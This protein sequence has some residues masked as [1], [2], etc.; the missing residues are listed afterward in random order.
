VAV[1]VAGAA[2]LLA[3]LDA[4]VVVTILTSVMADLEIPL[5]HLERATP[6]VSGYLLGYVAAMPLLGA[7]S[8]RAGRRPVILAC[9][10]GFALGSVVSAA[11]PSFWILVVGRVVQGA[12]GGALLPVTFALVGDLWEEGSRPVPLGLLAGAQE[13]GSMVGPLYGAGVAAVVGWRGLFWVNVPVAAAA[14]AAVRATVPAA[15]PPAAARRPFRPVPAIVLTGALGAIVVG[16][17]NP[18]PARAALPPWGP[19]M[20][21]AGAAGLIVA[22]ALERRADQPLLRP[23]TGRN[24]GAF[25][26]VLGVSF[27]AGAALMATLVD[28]PLIAQTLLGKDSVGGALVLTRFLLALAVGAVLGGALVRPAGERSVAAAGLALAALAYWLVAGWPAEVLSARHDLGPVSVPRLDADLVLAGLGLGLVIAPLASSAL[29]LTEPAQHG[30]A[31]AAVVLARMM[32]ML[33]G[34]A[35]LTAWGLHRFQQLTSDLVAPLPFGVPADVFAR[36]LAVYREAVQAALRAEYREI[37]LI[38]AAICAAAALL[39][40]AVGGRTRAPARVRDRAVAT[41]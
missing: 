28:V 27:L 40:L 34:I 24:V 36:R 16:L 17:Y 35:A 3:A 31:S 37:F 4:Y 22:V 39:S 20:V 23:A 30:V 14:G 33:V 18:D 1:G 15:A 6:M 8:D 32:G 41:R 25:G 9:L 29:R 26:A 21:G 2:V 11:A 10:G 7:L 38:T 12:A 5:N 13:L 19:W